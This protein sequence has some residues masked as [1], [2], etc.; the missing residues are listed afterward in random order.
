MSRY[1]SFKVVMG[2]RCFVKFLKLFNLFIL[3]T[4][5]HGLHFCN[6]AYK[7]LWDL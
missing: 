5:Q 2:M 7:D 1:E 4:L 6:P 3:L